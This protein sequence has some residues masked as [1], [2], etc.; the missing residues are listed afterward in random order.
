MTGV[1][2]NLVS[3]IME[4]AD[5]E[6]ITVGKEIQ[7][8]DRS[9]LEIELRDLHGLPTSGGMLDVRERLPWLP[10]QMCETTKEKKQG[11]AVLTEDFLFHH[12]SSRNII[13]IFLS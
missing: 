1:K 3:H 11:N 8:I 6:N 7:R 2:Y 4:Y 9:A 10:P 5:K 12:Q 13:L